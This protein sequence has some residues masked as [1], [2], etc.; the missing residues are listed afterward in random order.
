MSDIF[1]RL[2][3][4]V[5]DFKA[6]IASARAAAVEN[7]A[8]IE[9]GA[10]KLTAVFAGVGGAAGLLTKAMLEDFGVLEKFEIRMNAVT[11]SAEKTGRAL[12]TMKEY[13]AKTDIPLTSIEE[14][15]TKIL[16]LKGNIDEVLPLVGNY[17]TVMGESLPEASEKFTKALN[18]TDRAFQQILRAT[19]TTA[20][21]LR[22]TYGA[23]LDSTGKKVSTAGANAEK[24][25]DALIKLFTTKYGNAAEESGKTFDGALQHLKDSVMELGAEFGKTLA[26]AAIVLADGLK[27]L[28]EKLQAMPDI[29]KEVIAGAIVLTGVLASGI[30]IAAGA[31]IAYGALA[32]A[33][34]GVAAVLAPFAAGIVA[35]IAPLIALGVAFLTAKVAAEEMHKDMDYLDAENAKLEAS[36]RKHAQALHDLG[37]MAGKTAAQLVDA[38]VTA[39]K[40]VDAM[41]GVVEKIGRFRALQQQF[42][43]GSEEFNKI[44]KYIATLHAQ[45]DGFRNLAPQV[46]AVATAREKDAQA[47]QSA[48]ESFNA[49]KQA[50]VYATK[51]AELD[52]LD[53]VLAHSRL[54][55]DERKKLDLERVSVARAASK[56]KAE[57]ALKSLEEEASAGKI[58]K[59]EEAQQLRALA[60]EYAGVQ[61]FKRDAIAK[62]EQLERAATQQQL[63]DAAKVIEAQKSAKE[64]ALTTAEEKL[65]QGGNL[66]SQSTAIKAQIEAI[67]KLEIDQINARKAAELNKLAPTDATGRSAVEK[68]S[69]SQIDTVREQTKQRQLKRE[70]ELRGA[71][72][73]R[74]KAEVEAEEGKQKVIDSRL[75]QLEERQKS[76]EDVGAKIEAETKLRIAGEQSVLEAKK[77]GELATETD[78]TKRASIETAYNQQIA[79]KKIDGEVELDKRR[80]ESEK[81]SLGRV[82]ERI[83]L[84]E[85][86]RQEQA[87]LLQQRVARG[88]VS[89]AQAEREEKDLLREQIDLR[90]EQ[91]RVA[92]QIASVSKTP[93]EQAIIARD[94]QLQVNAALR[95]G[96][97]DM[98]TLNAKYKDGTSELDKTLKKLDQVKSQLNA[99]TGRDE[100]RDDD[101]GS[102]GTPYTQEEANQRAKDAAD[103]DRLQQRQKRLEAK[104]QEETRK[105]QQRNQTEASQQTTSVQANE[106]QRKVTEANIRRKLADSGLSPDEIDT[107]VNKTLGTGA[108]PA[109]AANPGTV[110]GSIAAGV[111]AGA[112]AVNASITANPGQGT[113]SRVTPPA[114]GSSSNPQAAAPPPVQLTNTITVNMPGGAQTATFTDVPTAVPK[115]PSV[116][117]PQPSNRG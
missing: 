24:A 116:F 50:G 39:A 82:Q 95:Q 27:F 96:A 98:G 33:L 115:A 18:G 67:G 22:D 64:A 53:A 73:D 48:Y 109:V 35:A 107:R 71:Q 76:G 105:Q 11:G 81:A 97:T 34:A 111:A 93:A 25:H 106:S 72:A 16:A 15:G 9:Q 5:D 77:R 108:N 23:V 75:K 83:S 54:D 42:A 49:N 56:E 2:R 70:E 13:A 104:A 103:K 102:A 55:A 32:P 99:I 59:A 37:E 114:T 86:E 20:K 60:Q 14:A 28:V 89:P 69:A 117:S 26:P 46:Q 92:G 43:P 17:A 84:A 12:K 113:T 44:E 87:A 41:A 45:A 4:E 88:D 110:N 38:G 21:E 19:G 40:V 112:G 57:A 1:V 47:A 100:A 36:E 65:K 90:V 31:A 52:A 94:T 79:A 29:T 63:D 7:F 30:A 51:Q 66:I 68:E 10:K 80:E 91:L 3:A 58:S 78:P 8:A 85:R 74:I 61:N 6:K 101:E 62:A